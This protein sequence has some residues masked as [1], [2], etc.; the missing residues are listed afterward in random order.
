M[1]YKEVYL[2]KGGG[3]LPDYASLQILDTQDRE[4]ARDRLI[5]AV[6]AY[7]DAQGYINCQRESAE[8][9]VAFAPTEKG[10][11]VFDDCAD[12]LDVTALNGLGRCLSGKL[13]DRVVGV[14]CSGNELMLCLYGEGM[15]KD[16]Y[17][18]SRR[19]PG[20]LPLS[21]WA[22]SHGHALRWRALLAEGHTIKE[23]AD[24]FTQGQLAGREI[25]AQLRLALALD[26]SA[27][28]GFASLEDAGLPGVVILHFRASNVV[29]Q[30]LW[31]KLMHPARRAATSAGAL[32]G[33]QTVRRE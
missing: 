2:A 5:Y 8:R 17:I 10:W 1:I 23:L 33:R 26:E 28:Y 6:T 15:V 7:M 18:T 19:F 16:T 4:T 20:Q 25:Y 32:L 22:R 21:I 12:R 30:S 11:A 31:D 24:I 29:R 9:T 13:R 14:M 27:G 3:A